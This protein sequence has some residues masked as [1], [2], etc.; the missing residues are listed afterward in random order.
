MLH[1]IHI[2]NTL[3]TQALIKNH[4]RI[5]NEALN[6]SVCT[7]TGYRNPP[8]STSLNHDADDFIILYICS[9]AVIHSSC[10]MGGANTKS[11]ETGLHV[12]HTDSCS[13]PSIVDMVFLFWPCIVAYVSP[14]GTQQSSTSSNI[15]P[16]SSWVSV[17][18]GFVLNLIDN[19]EEFKLV[20]ILLKAEWPELKSVGLDWL[21][22]LATQKKPKKFIKGA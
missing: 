4:E 3:T 14:S 13:I 16:P 11:S 19:E 21:S 7:F 10:T 5:L 18:T 15:S 9:V 17:M 12:N 2:E 1:Y 20:H 8:T 22:Y 6:E